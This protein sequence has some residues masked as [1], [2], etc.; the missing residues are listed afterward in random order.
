MY[1]KK[2]FSQYEPWS[3]AVPTYEKVVAADK[4]D[5]LEELLEEHFKGIPTETEVNDFLWFNNEYVLNLLGL[6][7]KEVELPT[8]YD[9][10]LDDMCIEIDEEEDIDA[11][12]NECGIEYLQDA[13]SPDFLKYTILGADFTRDLDEVHFL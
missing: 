13:V 11:A 4:L 10:T 9:C 1:F 3:G 6:V 7:E 12:I 2:D 5:E 8:E